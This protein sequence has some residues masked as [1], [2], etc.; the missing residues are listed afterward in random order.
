MEGDPKTLESPCKGVA[1]AA[2]EGRASMTWGWVLIIPG[3]STLLPADTE[4][5][6]IPLCPPKA[7]CL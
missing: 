5:R 6:G 2:E 3:L 4:M 7:Q 1:L